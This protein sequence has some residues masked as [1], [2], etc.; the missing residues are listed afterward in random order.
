MYCG[1]SVGGKGNQRR[2]G[3]EDEQRREGLWRRKMPW[4]GGGGRSGVDRYCF[5]EESLDS[6]NFAILT[7]QILPLYFQEESL[8]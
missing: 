5:V 2:K 8:N 6:Q 3:K 7:T 4:G 1:A